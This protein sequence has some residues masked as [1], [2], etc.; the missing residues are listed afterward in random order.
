MY[1]RY[2][3]SLSNVHAKLCLSWP[4]GMKH[5]MGLIW[6]TLGSHVFK[7]SCHVGRGEKTAASQMI[8]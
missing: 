2:V 7:D 5:L 4:G 6:P 1:Y 3:G 8:G